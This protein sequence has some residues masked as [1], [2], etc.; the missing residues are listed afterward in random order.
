[1]FWTFSKNKVILVA[2][3]EIKIILIYVFTIV[4]LILVAGNYR[5]I[6]NVFSNPTNVHFLFIEQKSERFLSKIDIFD[7]NWIFFQFRRFFQILN[8]NFWD[9]VNSERSEAEG[10]ARW[11]KRGVGARVYVRV[12][13]NLGCCT[14]IKIYLSQYSKFLH[15]SK[16]LSQHGRCNNVNSCVFISV[17]NK[18]NKKFTKN[19][20]L[21][22][23]K[24][25]CPTIFN[26]HLSDLSQQLCIVWRLNFRTPI[27]GLREW[28]WLD[29]DDIFIDFKVNRK[30]MKI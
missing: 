10:R 11:A 2:D 24:K 15:I 18:K 1:M 7:K 27:W 19:R 9:L 22:L 12:T 17:Q 5:N 16:N 3:N 30:K 14:K 26:F 20:L 4:G 25:S 28:N 21:K 29:T 13:K 23:N 6:Q 8:F